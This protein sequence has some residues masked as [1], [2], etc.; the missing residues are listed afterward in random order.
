VATAKAS[1]QDSRSWFAQENPRLGFS[2]C[3]T[4]ANGGPPA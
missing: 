1:L 2:L 4:D 3:W